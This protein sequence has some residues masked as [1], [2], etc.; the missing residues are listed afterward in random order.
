MTAPQDPFAA[1]D[2][3]QPAS[4]PP[5]YGQPSGYGTPPPAGPG[6]S[7]PPYGQ[8]PAQGFGYGDPSAR[9]YGTAP[10]AA[11]QGP[12]L[13]PWGTRAGGYLIDFLISVVVQLVLGQISY[14]LGQ[15]AGIGVFLYFGYLTG[16]TGQTPGRRVVGIRVLREV[17]G[18]PLGAGAG[19]GRG[20]LHILDALPF[21][22]GFFWPIWDAK[23]QTFADKLIKSV[24]IKG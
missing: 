17:D 2:P 24:V 9:P 19:I 23:K 13:A 22:L 8:A 3:Q 21:G 11:W 6:A 12:P 16:T 5:P 4:S 1:P 15:V 18:Q 10:A 7:P 14:G 20:F